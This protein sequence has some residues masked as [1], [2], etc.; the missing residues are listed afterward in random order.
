MNR[1]R[2]SIEIA[3][4]PQAVWDVVTDPQRLGDWVTLHRRLERAPDGPLRRGSTMD[5]ILHVPGASF[6]VHW[7]AEQVR[8]PSLLRWE[9][10][11]PVRSRASITYRLSSSADGG[12]RFQYENEFKPP[13]GPLGALAGRVVVE[14]F[15][16]REAERTLER[17]KQLLEAG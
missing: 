6:R 9:G 8:A 11:G 1:V 15:S 2:T 13:L 10:R 7:C 12:T 17:L 4:T 3:A 5:Q 16:R 14:G